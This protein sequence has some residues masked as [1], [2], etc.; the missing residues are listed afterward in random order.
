VLYNHIV[1][2]GGYQMRTPLKYLKLGIPG[3]LTIVLVLLISIRFYSYIFLVLFGLLGS[4]GGILFEK[5]ERRFQLEK[6]SRSPIFEHATT[7]RQIL[8]LNVLFFTCYGAS[9]FSLSQGLYTKPIIYYLFITLSA[10]F[11]AIEVFQVKNYRMGL[12]NLLK[13][14]LLAINVF[15]S[16]QI[17]YPLGVTS[18]DGV[19]NVMSRDRISVI[20]ILETGHIPQGHLYA[21]YPLHF[22]LVAI[23]SSI[24]SIDPMVSYPFLI[25]LVLASCILCIFVIGKT[26]VNLH[27]GL[28]AALIYSFM[29]YFSYFASHGHQMSY[30]LPYVIMSFMII[31]LFLYRG[32][33]KTSTKIVLF[34]LYI[35]LIFTHHLTS[36]YFLF[37]IFSIVLWKNVYSLISNEKQKVKQKIFFLILLYL[38]P[39]F[40][41]F[42]YSGLIGEFARTL[43]IFYQSF[44]IENTHSL[45]TLYD[46]LPL[47][48]LFLNTFGSGIAIMLAMFGFFFA[49]N[50]YSFF[51]SIIST[52]S[53]VILIVIAIGIFMPGHLIMPQRLFVLLQISGLVFISAFGILYLSRMRFTKIIVLV[54][55]GLYVFFSIA[56]T[57]SGPETSLFRGH[58]VGYVRTYITYNEKLAISWFD[59]HIGGHIEGVKPIYS[60]I[61]SNHTVSRIP[62]NH[63]NE[64][65]I[66]RIPKG[67]FILL[68]EL[69]F[70]SGFNPERPSS[71]RFSGFKFTFPDREKILA[72]LITNSNNIYTSRII[73]IYL[74]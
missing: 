7:K 68:N 52:V 13:L 12:F 19:A 49:L 67:T 5:L 17:I 60:S 38:T 70:I 9:F 27:F 71:A 42:T 25:G 6:F 1:F 4:I 14:W 24:T 32:V 72:Q 41:K 28:F 64:V 11:V 47:E 22:I 23:G 2:T 37:V 15:L 44:F 62:F 59:S 33:M 45:P 40:A 57:I 20:E 16:N 58:Q 69:D 30:A 34:I 53:I 21:H 26:F 74:I 29:D 65:D 3:V 63:K 35:G 55:L 39:M 8:I 61:F 43:E 66:E 48:I 10:I 50:K 51:G 73:H 31:L 46:T 18:I 54:L 56:S 36:M